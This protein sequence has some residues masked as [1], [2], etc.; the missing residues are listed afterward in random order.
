M[1]SRTLLL[2]WVS[3]LLTSCAA[4]GPDGQPKQSAEPDIRRLAQ[5]TAFEVAALDPS[6]TLFIL[7]VGTVE[8]HGPHLPLAADT[9]A[10]EFIVAGMTRALGDAL[11]GWSFIIMP[12]QAYSTEGANI[13][14]GMQVHRGTY[15]IRAETLRAIIADLGGQVAQNGFRWIFVVHGHGAPNHNI[16]ISDACDFVSDE[17]GVTML[18]LTSLHQGSR[19]FAE[20]RKSLAAARFSP[21][22][23]RTIGVD[24]HAGTHETSWTLAIRPDLVK[25]AYRE[26]PPLT[27]STLAE[28]VARGRE[29]EWQGYWSAPA[30]ADPAYGRLVME[31]DVAAHARIALRAIRGENFSSAPRYPDDI[32]RDSAMRAVN[33]ASLEHQRAFSER[34]D[35]WLEQRQ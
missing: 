34:L 10:T 9:Y 1:T 21:E 13:L 8:E 4:G 32:N 19:E 28:V 11:G 7:P 25:P 2:W 18:N 20:L 29:P 14:A 26:L 12:T 30:L 33:R 15:G 22:Q 6:R 27:A 24:L 17:F 16:A 3:L 35:R 23:L 5:M 31:P